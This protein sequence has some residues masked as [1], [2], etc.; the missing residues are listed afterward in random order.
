MQRIIL[1]SFL[2]F[3]I[4][5]SLNATV[6][7]VNRNSALGGDFTQVSTAMSSASVLAD[8]TLYVYGAS[9]DYTSVILTKRLTI[10]GPGYFLDQNTG[11]Q[12][13]PMSA[14]I[15]SFTFST[16][17]EGSLVAGLQFNFLSF[18][19]GNCVVQRCRTTQGVS[20]NRANCIISQCY[21]GS[22]VNIITLRLEGLA[23][24]TMV[25]NSYISYT[26]YDSINML[27]GSSATIANCVIRGGVT[28]YDA[29]FFNNI[30]NPSGT[31][32]WSVNA[33]CL[34]HHNVFMAYA[35]WDWDDHVSPVDNLTNVSTQVFEDSG[36]ADGMWQ[37]CDGSVAVGYG[38]GG[39]DCGM[40]GG[41]I[42]YIL[43]GIPAI[44]TIY[45]FTAPATGFTIPIQI[46]TR[47]NN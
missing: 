7:H 16:G 17:S 44:P 46:R 9:S 39:I 19:A 12:Q 8:D 10:I 2:L 15:P 29:E 34:I 30:L 25:T 31:P 43:S 5:S 40:Y 23:D 37:L 41:Q 38:T 33:N 24:N 28:L 42:P 13:N 35:G 6:W 20:V 47:S 14:H 4:C 32:T 45:E 36:T 27:S 26:N 21:F 18:N 3:F 1:F 11:L 22:S